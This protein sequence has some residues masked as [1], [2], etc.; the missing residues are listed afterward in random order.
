MK[1]IV[2]KV[3]DWGGVAQ[4]LAKHLKPGMI[5]A[6][7]GPLGA[8]KTTLVQALSRVLGAKGNPRSPTFSLVRSYQVNSGEIK[9][10]VHVDA[11]RIDDERDVLPLGLDELM[12]EPGTVIAIEWSERISSFLRK[13]NV[14][15][16][17]VTIE[18]AADGIRRVDVRE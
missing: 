1:Y 11:Y 4:S 14:P 6:L 18:A 10:L 2:A 8:G 3:E 17:S 7:S 12:S 15:V 5:L 13:W 9:Q 16:L